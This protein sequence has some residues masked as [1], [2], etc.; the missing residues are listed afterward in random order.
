MMEL[1]NDSLPFE[2]FAG[3][4]VVGFIGWA[5][6]KVFMIEAEASIAHLF[7]D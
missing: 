1:V 6:V 2:Y 3:A 4:G 5:V 7:E